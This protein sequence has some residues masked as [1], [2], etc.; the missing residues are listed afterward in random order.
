MNCSAGISWR[1]PSQIFAC[2]S[3][4]FEKEGKKVI[5]GGR[6]GVGWGRY[7]EAEI[8]GHGRAWRTFFSVFSDIPKRTTCTADNWVLLL[9]LSLTFTIGSINFRVKIA[10][11]TRN[12]LVPGVLPFSSPGTR[13]GTGRR[14][15]WKRGIRTQ[16]KHFLLLLTRKLFARFFHA[17]FLSCLAGYLSA[18][19]FN[20]SNFTIYSYVSVVF[21]SERQ[22]GFHWR[23]LRSSSSNHDTTPLTQTVHLVTRDRL[24]RTNLPPARKWNNKPQQ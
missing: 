7:W 2:C 1:E 22:T 9:K 5:E 24:S 18:F 6:G 4:E 16:K 21:T 11:L 19:S 20:A 15:T 8:G 10:S 3:Q 23:R 17:R 14:G 13:E 12:N